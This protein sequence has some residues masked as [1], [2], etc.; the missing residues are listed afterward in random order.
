[1]W[2]LGT[3]V[4]I[5]S[6]LSIAAR[7]SGYPATIPRPVVGLLERT[8]E[9]GAAVWWFTLGGPFESFPSD[10]GGYAVTVLGN[11]ACWCLAWMVVRTIGRRLIRAF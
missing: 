3:V 1:M 9:P 8:L 6:M 11:V 2:T 5:V 7:V 4:A 10:L